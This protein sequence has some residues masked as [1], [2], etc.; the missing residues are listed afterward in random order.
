MAGAALPL[1]KLFII[2]VINLIIIVRWLLPVAVVAG[3][4]L[5]V[6]EVKHRRSAA[7]TVGGHLGG[8]RHPPLQRFTT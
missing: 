1:L 6:S 7:A 8:G 5:T 2:P 3:W 4:P